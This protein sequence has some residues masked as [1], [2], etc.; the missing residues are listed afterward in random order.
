M[1]EKLLEMRKCG[2]MRAMQET[3]HLLGF[4]AGELTPW[5]STRYDLQAY[6]RGAERLENL[7][8]EP[9]GGVRRRPGT[10][11]VGAAS[12]QEDAVRLLPFVYA[13]NDALMLELYPGGMRVYRDGTLLQKDGQTYEL[14]T[15]WSSRE[16]VLGLRAVQ[17][18]DVVYVTCAQ[19]EPV[20]LMRYADTD[21]QWEVL[22]MNPY[23]RETY[24]AQAYGMQVLMEPGGRYAQL[25]TDTYA[26]VFEPEMVLNEYIVAEAHIPSRT[27]FMNEKMTV[28]ANELP[29]LSTAALPY[30][31]VYYIKNETTGMY[32]YYTCIRSYDYS[33]YNGSKSPIDY[34]NYFIAGVLRLDENGLPYEVCGDWELRTHGEWDGVWEL[35]RSYDDRETDVD[36]NRWSW[37]RLK[38]FGQTSYAE[39]QNWAL[40]GTEDTPCR[41][42]LVCKSAITS[43]IG[44]YLYFRVLGAMREYK[45]RI[46]RYDSPHSVRARVLTSHLGQYKSFYTRRWSFGAFGWR[47]G[48]PRF[49]A[50][51]QGRLWMGGIQGLPTTLFA[52]S[53][54]DYQHFGIN[55]ADDSALQLTLASDNQSQISWLCSSRGLLV[56]TSEGEWVLSAPDGG[57]ITGNNAAFVRHSSVGSE[58]LPACSMEHAVLFVQRGGRRVR[59]ISYKLEADGYTTTDVSLLAEHLFAPGVKEWMVQRGSS[60]HLWVLLHDGSVAVL[61][62]N[63]EQ[64]V[65]AWQRVTFPGRRILHIASL[66]HQGSHEDEVWF[67]LQNTQSGFVSLERMLD[68]GVCADGMRVLYPDAEGRVQAGLH[69]AGLRGLV[70][71]EEMPGEAVEVRFDA[72]GVCEIPAFVPDTEYAVGALFESELHTMPLEQ[73]MS[74]NAVR[75]LGRVK[76]RLLESDPHF[77]Y[78]SGHAK[79]WEVYNPDRDA[80][81][82]PYTGAIHVSHIPAPGEGQGF[83]LRVSGAL[84]FRLLSLTVEVD[85]H[86]K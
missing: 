70:F 54:N 7:L 78:R 17:V 50:F 1:P 79:R 10:E 75:Q 2:V 85:Y 36:F 38:T 44:A 56:G 28:K 24:A 9:Y 21:W 18:N 3:P 68:K 22:N 53:V 66:V 64:Q 63:A 81:V 11:Y 41:M 52:S 32:D 16:M 76:L 86:G 14:E 34:P 84:D 43:E 49:S 29:D 51:Y 27:L 67:V 12:V 15:P 62:T 30:N 39:R 48:Y 45:M 65:R 5:L 46:T 55:T 23:P 35:W 25:L 20:K 6:W 47:N 59:E 73:E 61:T 82:Y 37:T 58:N 72:Q 74:F 80:L 71:R 8:V 31:T 13:E 42:V 60:S 33:A 4:T 26:P 69:V 57:S 77:E 40:S 19:Y 83:C